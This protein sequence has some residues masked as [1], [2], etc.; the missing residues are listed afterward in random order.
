MIQQL[1]QELGFSTNIG[2]IYV[3]LIEAGA[4]S[5]RQLSDAL[6]LP[7]PTIY[8]GLKSLIQAG[9]VVE[10]NEEGKKVFQTDEIRN[11]PE[12]V[13]TKIEKLQQS[14]RSLKTMLPKLRRQGAS[15]QPRMKFYPGAEGVKR[16][17]G[18]TLWEED[19]EVIAL[20]PFSEM[21]DVL[22]EEYLREYNK[23]RIRRRIA[24]RMI[25]PQ[26][27]AVRLEKYPFLGLSPR[28]LRKLRLAPRGLTWKMG[29]AVYGDKTSFISSRDEMFGFIIQSRDLAD[30]QR[31]QFE[32]IWKQSQPVRPIPGHGD[33]FLK[34][35]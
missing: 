18:D 11:L 14:E 5:A 26:D 30:L 16:V 34:T 22:G 25:W 32:M 13:R 29:T 9:L 4:S 2:R 15:L 3:R 28:H 10:R 21:V 12:L 19:M 23:R 20:W 27:K 24:V 8:D 35:V 17:L 6:S 31:V 1:F 7:R 33:D